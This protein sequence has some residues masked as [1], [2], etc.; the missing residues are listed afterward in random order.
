MAAGESEFAIPRSVAVQLR[1]TSQLSTSVVSFIYFHVFIFFTGTPAK[2]YCGPAFNKH[3]L[4][5]PV[6]I[7]CSAL[8]VQLEKVRA[9]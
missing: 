8:A 3:H 1:V 9:E 5:S 4:L 2:V 6:H 7:D